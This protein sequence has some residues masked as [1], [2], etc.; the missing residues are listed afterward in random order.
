MAGQGKGL[1]GPA[2]IPAVARRT[3]VAVYHLQVFRPGATPGARSP[4]VPTC[5]CR[6]FAWRVLLLFLAGAAPAAAG[7]WALAIYAGRMTDDGWRA[8]LAGRAAFVD[9][10]LVAGAVRRTLWRGDAWSLEAEG[11]VARHVGAQRHWEFDA[12]G[13]VRFHGF[14]WRRALPTSFSFGAGPSY[15]TRVPPVEERLDGESAK[16]LLYWHFELT[17]GPPSQAWEALF[18]LHHRSTSYGVFGDTGGGNV[19]AAGLRFFF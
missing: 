7:D 13:G 11:I 3:A 10:G 12:L 9:A 19:L 6:R 16:R 5:R 1:A 15:A 18:R 8:S 2:R 14:P 4:P 17:L